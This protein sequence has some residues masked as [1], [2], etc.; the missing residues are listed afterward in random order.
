MKRAAAMVKRVMAGFMG[1]GGSVGVGRSLGKLPGFAPSGHRV[2]ATRFRYD[3]RARR[4]YRE[5]L[6]L[7]STI[8]SGQHSVEDAKLTGS[9]FRDVC[10]GGAVFEDVNL[11]DARFR[12]VNLSGARFDDVNLSRVEITNANYA[13]M[14]IDGISVSELLAAHRRGG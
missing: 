11:G 3:G 14:T 5:E 13:G 7:A 1:G 10:L 6:P 2:I 4:P 12:D 8:P 9:T